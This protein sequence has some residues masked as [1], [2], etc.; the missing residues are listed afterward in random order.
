L[1]GGLR[2]ISSADDYTLYYHDTEECPF[3]LA[4]FAKD[5]RLTLFKISRKQITVRKKRNLSAR[6]ANAARLG[7]NLAK[8]GY[9]YFHQ[10]RAIEDL[11]KQDLL[12]YPWPFQSEP[13]DLDKPVVFVPHDLIFTHYFGHHVGNYYSRENCEKSARRI[14]RYAEIGRAIV[15]SRYIADE[16]ARF[17]R[18]Y[19]QPIEIVPLASLS[20]SRKPEDGFCRVVLEKHDIVGEYLLLPTNSMHHKNIGQVLGAFYY[21]K[22][23]FPGIKLIILGYGTEGI[24]VACNSPYYCDHVK[25]SEPYD[26]KSLGFVS[27]DEAKALFSKARIV[28]NASLCEAGCGSGLDAWSI[29]VPTAISCIPPYLEQVETLGVKTAFFDPRNSSDMART[30]ISLLENPVLAKENATISS[31]RIAEYSWEHVAKRYR[32]VFCATYESY[33]QK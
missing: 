28:I 31:S 11:H 32:E 8:R 17:F 12:F 15:S 30:I 18:E 25:E 1:I 16:F 14:S 6:F 19:A 29:G 3:D 7:I 21:V 5:K 20:D 33:Q 4:E 23:E 27:D 2:A 26:I 10:V 22:Q 9:N 24:R 13:Y